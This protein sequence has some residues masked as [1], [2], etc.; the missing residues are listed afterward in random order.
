MQTT[1]SI[2]FLCTSADA[3]DEFDQGAP[4][5]FLPG[6]DARKVENFEHMYKIAIR[7]AIF[8]PSTEKDKKFIQQASK[9]FPFFEELLMK[10]KGNKSK[11]I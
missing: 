7:N 2:R 6:Q 5:T 3:A 11:T 4:P 9:R 10:V 8:K 1:R